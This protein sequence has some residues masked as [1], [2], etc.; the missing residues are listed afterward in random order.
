M[1]YYLPTFTAYRKMPWYIYKIYH[2]RNYA[3][4]IKKCL[5]GSQSAPHHHHR[6]WHCT[7]RIIARNSKVTAYGIGDYQ[8]KN[9]EVY[10]ACY[11][12]VLTTKMNNIGNMILYNN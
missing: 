9:V 7:G 8:D 10:N 12:C 5:L 6:R 3:W 4:T 11:T 2:N 1:F